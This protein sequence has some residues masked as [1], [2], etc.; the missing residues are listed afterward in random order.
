M[1]F[2]SCHKLIFKFICLCNPM[3]KLK[4]SNV[5]TIRLQMH[6]DQT[7]FSSKNGVPLFDY[8]KNVKILYISQFISQYYLLLTSSSYS[9]FIISYRPKRCPLQLT[10]KLQSY[11]IPSSLSIVYPNLSPSPAKPLYSH[12]LFDPVIYYALPQPTQHMK[13]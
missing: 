8:P 5:Y 11:R 10:S 3:F 4:I 12:L 6:R 13:L 2:L 1:F 9:L 7:S